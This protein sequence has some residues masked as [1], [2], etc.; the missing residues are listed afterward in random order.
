MKNGSCAVSHEDACAR[1]S[2]RF[3]ERWLRIYAGRK[4]RSDPIFPAAYEL[5]GQSDQPLL[6]VGCGVGLLAFY[7]R[8]RNFLPPISGFDRDGRKIER[9]N[10]VARGIYH[11]LEFLERDV[12]EPITRGGNIVLFDLLHYLPPND[13]AGLLA[14]LAQRVAPGGTLVIRDCPRDQNARFWLTNLAERFAQGT[15][16]NMKTALHFPSRE[17]I[18]AA[19]PEHEFSRRV[20]PLWGRTPFNN[21]LFI[22]RRDPSAT[23]PAGAGHSGS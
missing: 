16:W 2:A 15:T 13:Q 8:E 17:T 23:V 22:F 1:V 14:R 9:A 18:V 21:H 5:F 19:F 4:L 20:T 7:L 3:G 10:A 6:D 11:D 12:S